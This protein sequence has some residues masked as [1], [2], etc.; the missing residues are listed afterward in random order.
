MPRYTKGPP[1]SQQQSPTVPSAVQFRVTLG[2]M[3]LQDAYS[4]ISPG[5]SSDETLGTLLSR[6]FTLHLSTRMGEEIMSGLPLDPDSLAMHA[7]LAKMIYDSHAARCSLRFFVNHGPEIDATDQVVPHFGQVGADA[8]SWQLDVVVEQRF[9]PFEY[10]IS[11]GDWSSEP[12]LM[13]W[14]EDSTALLLADAESPNIS[15][16]TARRL[17]EQGLFEP[18]T[19]QGPRDITDAGRAKRNELE[20]ETESYVEQYGLFEDVLYDD[21]A[22]VA[23]FGTGLGQDLRPLIYEAESLDPVRITFLLSMLGSADDALD[24]QDPQRFFTALL[25]PA[26]DRPYLDNADVE[27][28]IETGLALVELDAEAKQRDIAR[29]QAVSHAR[30]QTPPQGDQAHS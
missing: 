28:I 24:T 8:D 17:V 10:A 2:D 11:R 13:D 22:Q 19:P 14:L 23:D 4:V 15:E 30:R 12:E 20:S 3:P 7:E 21:E 16:V 27:Q 18:Q 5:I 25:T 29:R 9:T 6:L 26:V 1:P